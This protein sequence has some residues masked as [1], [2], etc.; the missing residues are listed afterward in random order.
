MFTNGVFDL[1]HRG[2][3]TLLEAARAEGDVLVVGINSDASTRRIKGEGRPHITESDRA[4]LIAAMGAV[5][6][7]VVFDEDTPLQLIQALEPDVLVKGTDYARTDTVGADIVESRGG[8]VTHVNLALD[9]VT[10]KALSSTSIA[11]RIRGST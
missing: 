8:R 6:C 3:I 11:Q 1:L 10:T 4:R 2:H 9:P 5:D 7:V